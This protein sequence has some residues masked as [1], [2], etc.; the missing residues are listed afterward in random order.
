MVFQISIVKNKKIS[1][2]VNIKVCYKYLLGLGKGLD[3]NKLLY[4]LEEILL[5]QAGN[6][7]FTTDYYKSLNVSIYFHL[8]SRN[9]FV[10]RK[11][12][13]QI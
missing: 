7:I 9:S 3:E 8:N 4:I 2:I 10:R 6:Q 1:T 11:N 13:E 5:S 12:S